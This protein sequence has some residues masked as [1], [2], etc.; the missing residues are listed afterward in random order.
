MA[1]QGREG[2]IDLL[3]E[4]GACEFMRKG[5]VG[6][7]QQQIGSLGPAG[8]KAIVPANHKEEIARFTFGG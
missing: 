8:R 4:H 7:R 6:K 1:P 5:H 2:A 3:G